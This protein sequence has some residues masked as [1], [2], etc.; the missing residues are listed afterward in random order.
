[1]GLLKQSTAYTVMFPMVDS[2]DHLAPKT[3]LTV[4]VN[5]SKAGGSFGAA[6]GTVT[7][8]A[9]GWYKCALTTTD[10][11]TLGDLAFHCTATGADPTQFKEQVVAVDVGD[12]AAFGLSRLDAA[13]SSRSTLTAANVWDALTSG[14]TTANSI[15]KRLAD[16]VD[17]TISSRLATSGYAAPPSAASISS[18][19][20]AETTR[21]LTDKA[22]FALSAA[23]VQAIWDA[24]TS[25]LT[26]VGSVGKRIADDL[27]ATVSSRLASAGYTAPDNAG[28]STL[29]GRLT[30]GRATNL[31]NL[32][33]A[34]S[35]RS[36]HTAADVWA[37]ATRTLSAFAFSVTV[38]TN[39]DKTGYGLSAAAVQ[40]IWDALTS[41]LSTANSV[42][43]LI[44]DNLN[45]TVSSRLA[46]A[47][48]TAPPTVAQVADQVWDEGLSGHLTAG[49][50]GEALNGAGG[51]GTPPTSAEIA[52]AV[53]DELIA[54]HLGAG[55]TG[56]QLT[57]AASAGDPWSTPLPGPY[58]PGTAGDLLGNRLFL[59][60]AEVTVSSPV[61]A[62]GTRIELVRGSAYATADGRALSFS[63]DAW[64]TLTGAS[65]TLDIGAYVSVAGTMVSGSGTKVVRFDL[66]AAQTAD[67]P[68][69]SHPFEVAALISGRA[70]TLVLGTATVLEGVP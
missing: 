44:V 3:G 68:Q 38:G 32:D 43:K 70:V 19:V 67:L 27:D 20:W 63:S 10:T 42:G 47:S 31:D 69:G 18:T 6:G 11:N 41:A 59:D 60:A 48:Y 56:A 46:S 2:S 8:V 15:G 17:A 4:T 52:D 54:G 21:A 39:N 49:S 9:N 22:G 26:T 64:P 34:V 12:A 51:G 55:S 24:L 40:A 30:A 1:M 16:D 37:S 57:S 58:A 45:A 29:T 62:N 25:A 28:I 14:L 7:E 36:S 33:A 5:I 35:S 23:G 61:S 13:V 53:W 65:V 50:T 66:T